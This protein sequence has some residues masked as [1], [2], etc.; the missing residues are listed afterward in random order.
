[1]APNI[2]T[3]LETG[4]THARQAR[5][6]AAMTFSTYYFYFSRVGRLPHAG[7]EGKP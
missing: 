1:M 5:V 2:E 6:R 3:Q 4:L 7:W